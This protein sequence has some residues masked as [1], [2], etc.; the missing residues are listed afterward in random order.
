MIFDQAPLS[1][2]RMVLVDTGQPRNIGASAR[3]IKTMGLSRLYLVRP[4]EY[5]HVQ[6][7][8]LA[9]SAIDVLET[10]VICPDLAT[11]VAGCVA[12]YGVSARQRRIPLPWGAPRE[13]AP[14]IITH[15][16]GGD[17]AVVFGSEEAGLSSDDLDRCGTL[18]QIPSDPKCRS[19]NLAAAVQLVSYELRLAAATTAPS[20][21]QDAPIEAFEA[22]LFAL[23]Q[24]L[25]SADFFANKN[26]A[27]AMLKLRRVLQRAQPDRAELNLLRG[28]LKQ[29]QRRL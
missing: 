6:A 19:L 16:R 24:T 28:A 4:R 21:R 17:V 22:L 23:E 9:V 27:L 11:A 7:E 2:L 3:A 29:V 12:V 13:L 26:Q 20:S 18:V 10:A 5:P 25:L 15:A 8:V 14:Q 1:R